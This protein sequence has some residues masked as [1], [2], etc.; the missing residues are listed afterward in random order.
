MSS[1]NRS[2]CKASAEAQALGKGAFVTHQV[3]RR[4][5]RGGRIHDRWCRRHSAQ[6]WRSRSAAATRA[7]RGSSTRRSAWPSWSATAATRDRRRLGIEVDHI[8]GSSPDLSNLQRLCH[9]CHQEKTARNFLP[10]VAG[11]AEEL[12][13]LE[14]DLR[15][16]SDQPLRLCDDEAVANT[17]EA[18]GDSAQGAV[19]GYDCPATGRVARSLPWHRRRCSSWARQFE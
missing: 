2:S 10:I 3:A 7:K 12:R 9:A 16:A 1:V 6:G 4:V 13:R 14:L 8:V 15:V 19:L 5:T 17:L 18:A 11:R